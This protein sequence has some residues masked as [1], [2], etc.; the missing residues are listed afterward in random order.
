[1]YMWPTKHIGRQTH[2]DRRTCRHTGLTVSWFLLA[3]ESGQVTVV[4]LSAT[5]EPWRRRSNAVHNHS[6]NHA[7]FTITS[8][9]F[10]FT[11]C[12]YNHNDDDNHD[13]DKIF[14]NDKVSY[15]SAH[16][17]GLKVKMII[18][19]KKSRKHSDNA[20]LHQVHILNFAKSH[21]YFMLKLLV[22]AK[23][24]SDCQIVWSQTM[25]ELLRFDEFQYGGCDLE[26]WPWPLKSIFEILNICA[27]FH[28]KM[29]L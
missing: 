22:A 27:K 8:F 9:T 17:D 14:I 25:A 19:V 13:D 2:R 18:I 11:D 1:M 4:G 16:C 29:D 10:C 24:P 3:G 7:G 5:L 20:N 15:P 23:Y 21:I 28:F 6:H 12:R 26:L